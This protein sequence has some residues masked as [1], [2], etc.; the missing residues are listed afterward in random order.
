MNIYDPISEALGIPSIK[1]IYDFS[2]VTHLK[3]IAPHNK[4]VPMSE[5]QKKLISETHIKNNYGKKAVKN[6]KPPPRG[7]KNW[8]KNSASV[9]KLRQLVTGRRRSYREDG[10]WC[11]CYP[12]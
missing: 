1:I 6:L 11:W 10:S 4:G 2:D 8:M 5:E 9:E 3:C 12:S 7:D